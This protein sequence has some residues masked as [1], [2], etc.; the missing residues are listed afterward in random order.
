M[1][2]ILYICDLEIRCVMD[3][4]VIQKKEIL[5]AKECA[6]LL[7]TSQRAIYNL[8]HRRVIPCYHVENGRRVL[9][10]RDEVLGW[11]L[12]KKSNEVV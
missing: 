1:Q 4:E 7:G 2:L 3:I 12:S 5:T 8:I 9:F 6:E 11:A 10:R